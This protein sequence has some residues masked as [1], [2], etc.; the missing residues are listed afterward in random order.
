MLVEDDGLVLVDAG[1]A[2]SRRLISV[3]LRKAG[4][5]MD[6]ISIVAVTHYHPDHTGGLNAL[7]KRHSVPVAA[8]ELEAPIISREADYP[9]PFNSRALGLFAWPLVRA[10]ADGGA[11]VAHRLRDGDALPSAGGVRVVHTPGHTA[12]SMSLFVESK[13][14]LIVGDALQHPRGNLRPPARHVTRDFSLAIESLK[15][16]EELDFET[17]C[18]SHFPPMRVRARESIQRLIDDHQEPR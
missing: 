13:K 10:L 12:G 5:S 8:H 1:S 16:L 6:D 11:P 7:S 9:S 3:G 2:G 15:S 17:I 18:F 4:Y 14:L